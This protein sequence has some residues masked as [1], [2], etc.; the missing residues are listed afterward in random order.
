M[1]KEKK[2]DK[3]LDN[4]IRGI[5]NRSIKSPIKNKNIHLK[6]RSIILETSANEVILDGFATGL[7]R[8]KKTSMLL[9][10]G[11]RETMIGLQLAA[12]I[13]AR[14]TGG[15]KKLRGVTSGATGSFIECVEVEFS[16]RIEKGKDFVSGSVKGSL[17]NEIEKITDGPQIL[18]GMDFL[19]QERGKRMKIELE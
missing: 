2:Y 12:S 19:T 17:M 6:N 4:T 14:L 18:L 3:T 11:A 9:D 15:V 5:F 10:T 7:L 1:F 8:T 13:G 16:L